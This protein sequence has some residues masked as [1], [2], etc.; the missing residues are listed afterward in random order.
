[1]L[2]HGADGGIESLK[3]KRSLEVVYHTLVN[4]I[5][6]MACVFAVVGVWCCE[7]TTYTNEDIHFIPFFHRD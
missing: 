6:K 2:W 3:G 1:M 5:R 4:V 7:K